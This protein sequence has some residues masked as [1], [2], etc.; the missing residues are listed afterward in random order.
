MCV[1]LPCYL[2]LNY[3][4]SENPSTQPAPSTL[5][6]Y[7]WWPQV[8]SR[9]W[10]S[11]LETE[12]GK[13]KNS[14]DDTKCAKERDDGR[15]A[16]W[17]DGIMVV[18]C[19]HLVIYGF[20]IMTR[21]ESPNDVFTVLSTRI[22]PESRPAVI[23]YDN[24][25]KLV[26]YILKREPQLLAKTRICVDRFHFGPI[27]KPIHNCSPAFCPTTYHNYLG[28]FLV[29]CNDNA[30]FNIRSYAFCLLKLIRKL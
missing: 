7:P 8:A 24:G 6:V 30:L 1:S 10:Y 21:K 27:Q 11:K 4:N 3:S 5:S 12:D 13:S 26:Q 15:D 9:P 16:N 19:P 2:K 14:S 29:V 17:T 22:P 20:H 25:C 18:V 28:M 23:F